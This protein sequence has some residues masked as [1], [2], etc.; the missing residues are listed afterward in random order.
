ML[1]VD[2]LQK[3]ILDMNN[4]ASEGSACEFLVDKLAPQVKRY[5]SRSRSWEIVLRG[6]FRSSN[7]HW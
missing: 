5:I 3:K 4:T 1:T 7:R 6:K 2:V